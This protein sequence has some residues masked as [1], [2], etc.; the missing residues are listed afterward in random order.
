MFVP[1]AFFAVVREKN[2]NNPETG[3]D[4]TETFRPLNQHVFSQCIVSEYAVVWLPVFQELSWA[5][6]KLAAGISQEF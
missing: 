3:S 5:V 1:L 6:S 4:A 2:G